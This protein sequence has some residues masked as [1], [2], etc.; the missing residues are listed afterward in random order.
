LL[1]V[2]ARQLIAEAWTEGEAAHLALDA[3]GI[4]PI[5][6]GD[7]TFLEDL[8]ENGVMKCSLLPRGE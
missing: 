2:D 6:A 1:D 7:D 4:A 8:V 5:A 3:T